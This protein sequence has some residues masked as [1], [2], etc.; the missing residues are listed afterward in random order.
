MQFYTVWLVT[1]KLTFPICSLYPIKPHFWVK[2]HFFHARIFWKRNKNLYQLK[3]ALLRILLDPILLSSI[4]MLLPTAIA[5]LRFKE[6]KQW[7][8]GFLSRYDYFILVTSTLAVKSSS[9]LRFV[10]K[11]NY[12]RKNNTGTFFAFIQ[13]SLFLQQCPCQC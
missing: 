13:F 4:L 7:L 1:R 8:P 11:K 12:F 6:N 10:F 5:F 3:C 2:P 9:G